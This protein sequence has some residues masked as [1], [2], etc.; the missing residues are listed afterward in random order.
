M[1]L[2]ITILLIF[3]AYAVY[4]QTG[5]LNNNQYII[6]DGRSCQYMGKTSTCAGI[7]TFDNRIIFSQTD[8][9]VIGNTLTERSFIDTIDATGCRII[10][11]N[12]LK[13]GDVLRITSRNI[14]SST[15]NPTNKIRILFGN[16][17]IIYSSET[18]ATGHTQTYA[19]INCDMRVIYRTGKYYLHGLGRTI[20]VG[21][22]Q[23]TLATDF[24]G[25]G[26][27]ID[28]TVANKIDWTY[29]WGAASADNE[30]I[31]ITNIIQILN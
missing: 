6:E 20:L 8:T 30:L 2:A 11:A 10:P 27:E 21:G 23:R 24:T 31:S 22:Q 26:V 15:G 1:K 3:I 16:D 4:C 28:I 14:F 29:E 7:P 17:T 12:T 19:E 13:N 5:G 9:V 25:V 18:L